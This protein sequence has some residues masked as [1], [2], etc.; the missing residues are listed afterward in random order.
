MGHWEPDRYID[1]RYD[2]W[3]NRCDSDTE[4]SMGICLECADPPP[5]AN[6]ALVKKKKTT[7][8]KTVQCTIMEST[9]EEGS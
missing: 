6:H 1:E 4:H 8:Q 2:E 9:L 5:A 3:C 7:V